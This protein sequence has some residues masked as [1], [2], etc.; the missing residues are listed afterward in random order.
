[1]LKIL[2]RIIYGNLSRRFNLIPPSPVS[3]TLN[4]TNKCNLSCKT[5]N[6]NNGEGV[7][8]LSQKEWEVVFQNLRGGIF[9]VTITGGEPF[10]REDFSSIIVCLLKLINPWVLT[11]A[12]NGSIPLKIEKD[13]KFIQKYNKKTKILLN[14]SLDG[15][16][17]LHNYI[18]GANC[19]SEVIT[20]YRILK[21][22]NLPY[23]SVGIGSVVSRYN[24]NHFFRLLKLVEEL[25]PD[26]FVCEPAQERV[27]LKN[28]GFKISPSQEEYADWIKNYL[29]KI[30]G[31]RSFIPL[32]VNSFRETYYPL[33]LKIMQEERQII[34]CFAGFLSAQISAAG[35]VWACGVKADKMGDLR[36]EDYQFDKIWRSHQAQMVRE[37]IKNGYCY[38][39]QAN[40]SYINILNNFPY[41]FKTGLKILKRLVG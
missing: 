25:K 15:D 10:L 14:I 8:E 41:L 26:S 2:P 40:I 5:C 39:P 6:I 22:S 12:T 32:I 29:P 24:I 11:I 31:N 20:T 19:F 23:L 17:E 7:D 34:P 30:S 28:I 27:E 13:L 18:R 4:L 38:C 35:E 36:N 37:R 33:S 21:E 9:W 16:E 3:L 1:M